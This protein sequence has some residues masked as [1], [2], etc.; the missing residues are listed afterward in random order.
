MSYS[1]S[2]LSYVAT[3]A[4]GCGN[5]LVSRPEEFPTLE[6]DVDAKRGASFCDTL[7][8]L[9]MP[10]V[11]DLDLSH[12]DKKLQKRFRKMPSAFTYTW[13]GNIG[14]IKDV[15]HRVTL[16]EDAESFR[17][18]PNKTGPAGCTEVRKA[19][20]AMKEDGVIRDAKPERASPVVLIPNSDGSMRFCVDYRRL[21]ELTVRDPYPLPRMDDCLDSLGEAAFFT[22]LDC[23]SRYWQIPVAGE[24]RAK[25]A[26]TFDECCF[27]FCRMPVGL[28]NAPETFQPTVAML[29]SA[30]RW[31]T[32]LVYLDDII[33][34]SNIAEEHVDHVK[35]VLT[36]SKAA[37]LSLKLRSASSLQIP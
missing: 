1:L 15:E 6:P 11:D 13:G 4:T 12:L 26:F 35:E 31:R 30:Y 34:F 24:D 14:V 36:V 19:V 9:P 16:R 17:I 25:T 20:T 21:N 22:T 37:G 7:L 33:V 23:N 2:G 28:C 10:S 18:N 8:E 32:C 3:V 29:L 27:E 5:S